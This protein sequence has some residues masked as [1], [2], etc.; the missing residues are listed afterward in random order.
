MMGK[1]AASD[2]VTSPG[3]SVQRE[4]STAPEGGEAMA[5]ETQNPATNPAPGATLQMAR[6]EAESL[7]RTQIDRAS[8]LLELAIENEP[9]LRQAEDEGEKW[10]DVN[11]ELLRRIVGTNQ[12]VNIYQPVGATLRQRREALPKKVSTFQSE[13]RSSIDS[14]ESVLGRLELIPESS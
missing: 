8:E 10:S 5:E 1:T 6:A 11:E 4:K 13:I 7:L 3:L 9:G 12:L 2:A 14:L